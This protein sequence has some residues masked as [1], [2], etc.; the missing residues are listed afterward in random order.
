MDVTFLVRVVVTAQSAELVEA[1]DV[2]VVHARPSDELLKRHAHGKSSSRL[3]HER[4]RHGRIGRVPRNL[5]LALAC[6]G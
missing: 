2:V 4:R 1:V 5:V 3:A 6:P